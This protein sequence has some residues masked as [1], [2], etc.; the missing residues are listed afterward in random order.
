MIDG[1]LCSTHSIQP[2]NL[3]AVSSG[4]RL[5][6]GSLTP[7]QDAT[8]QEE[9]GSCERESE[10]QRDREKAGCCELLSSRK[11]NFQR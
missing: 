11:K 3:F 10:E 1:N 4:S 9:S 7:A 6:A 5:P 2:S 8:L